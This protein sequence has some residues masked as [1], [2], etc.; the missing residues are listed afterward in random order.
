MSLSVPDRKSVCPNLNPLDCYLADIVADVRPLILF[1]E[2]I[3]DKSLELL[4]SYETFYVYYF[5]KIGPKFCDL[6][7]CYFS[8]SS[9]SK[10]DI[11]CARP[12]TELL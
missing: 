12:M 8:F 11:F 5:I 7:F 3:R 9:S 4:L 1:Y 2:V 6:C 10:E